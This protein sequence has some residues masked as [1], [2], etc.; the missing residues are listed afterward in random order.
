MI[1]ITIIQIM[2]CFILSVNLVF[3]HHKMA[4][5]VNTALRRARIDVNERTRRCKPD[6]KPV[7][8]D[9]DPGSCFDVSSI[10]F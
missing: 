5:N 10:Q 3:F 6:V 9:V 7:L 4:Y 8:S 1:A 2:F